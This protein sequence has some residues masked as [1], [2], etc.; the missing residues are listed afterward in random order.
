M[1]GRPLCLMFP[2][3]SYRFS[4][5][6]R[7]VLDFLVLEVWSPFRLGAIILCL[8]GMRWMWL[9]FCPCLR[10]LFLD[11]GEMILVGEIPIL[12]RDFWET[13][14]VISLLIVLS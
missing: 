13:P 2:H 11:G 4:F 10:W 8:V 9:P 7:V 3:L 6:D 5:K 14:F 12:L 1:G